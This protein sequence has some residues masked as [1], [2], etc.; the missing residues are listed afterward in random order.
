MLLFEKVCVL[1]KEAVVG[2]DL[3][4]VPGA[5]LEFEAKSW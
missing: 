2:T 4:L 3:E 5:A 1:P